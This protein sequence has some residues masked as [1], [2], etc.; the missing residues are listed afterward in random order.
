MFSAFCHFVTGVYICLIAIACICFL[1]IKNSFIHSINVIIY[2]IMYLF[3]QTCLFRCRCL[4]YLLYTHQQVTQSLHD[5]VTQFLSRSLGPSW[6]WSY[7]RWIYSYLCNHCLSPLTVFSSN[8]TQ[9]R[10]TRCNIMWSSLSVNCSRSVVFYGY[11]VFL[12]Q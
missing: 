9:A 12:Y 6:S 1:Q 10:C 5:N 2:D 11:S 3:N 7:G 8:P 4:F